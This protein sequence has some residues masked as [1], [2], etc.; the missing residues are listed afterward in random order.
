LKLNFFN[1]FTQLGVTIISLVLL[2]ACGSNEQLEFARKLLNQEKILFI[3]S[4][5]FFLLASLIVVVCWKYLAKRNKDKVQKKYNELLIHKIEEQYTGISQELHDVVGSELVLLKW[6]VSDK[7]GDEAVCRIED[8]LSNLRSMSRSM[9]PKDIESQEIK[10]IL[11]SYLRKLEDS[12]DVQLSYSIAQIVGLSKTLKLQLY[13][14]TQEATAN[15]LKHSQSSVLSVRL[16]LGDEM[17]ILEVEDEGI[18]FCK[19]AV[20]DSFGLY[21]MQQRA[22]RIGAK[23]KVKSK[24]GRG[25][26]IILTLKNPYLH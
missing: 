15:A 12:T 6:L 10:Q 3:V 5:V 23:L 19:I 11:E 9:H 14:I 16:N 26:K 17:I 20:K 8:A 22:T 2:S 21:V 24:R 13:R 18:G 4:L 1:P 25:T 7:D